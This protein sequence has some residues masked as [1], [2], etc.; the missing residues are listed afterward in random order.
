MDAMSSDAMLLYQLL[1]KSWAILSLARVA[2]VLP[3]SITLAF[4]LFWCA[5]G[6]LQEGNITQYVN[7]KV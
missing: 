1:D 6:I 4:T 7:L 2:M 5:A 3:A